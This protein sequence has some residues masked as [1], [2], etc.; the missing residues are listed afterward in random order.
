MC[1]TIL[2][3]LYF[4][5]I[6]IITNNCITW[7]NKSSQIFD[8]HIRPKLLSHFCHIDIVYYIYYT[9]SLPL[10][11]IWRLINLLWIILDS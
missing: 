1:L 10:L 2:R 7:Q 4:F 3:Y 6:L 8:T 11:I 9:S 5:Y